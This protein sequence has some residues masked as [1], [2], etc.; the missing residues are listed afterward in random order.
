MIT[1]QTFFLG[2]YSSSQFIVGK[3][4]GIF[5]NLNNLVLRVQEICR[6]ETIFIFVSLHNFTFIHGHMFCPKISCKTLIEST[7][8]Q[9]FHSWKSLV[10]QH[11]KT[12]TRI[13]HH[14]T[15]SPSYQVK[16]VHSCS[17]RICPGR[18]D[19]RVAICQGER[20]DH[21]FYTYIQNANHIRELLL[22]AK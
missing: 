3:Q 1:C 22:P 14:S 16:Q 15:R 21:Q 2:I 5:S 19:V 6:K 9:S 17:G 4:S 11:L 18:G 12:K 10:M 13:D 20:L 7:F 8:V